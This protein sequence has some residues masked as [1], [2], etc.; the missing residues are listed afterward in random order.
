MRALTSWKLA[1]TVFESG[2][3][4]MTP[5]SSLTSMLFVQAIRFLEGALLRRVEV[6][7]F[8]VF[9]LDLEW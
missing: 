4:F 8:G 5:S 3:A 6:K 1:D 2:D 7:P 9:Y